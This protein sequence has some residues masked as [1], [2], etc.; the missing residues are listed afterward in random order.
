[1]I[2]EPVP[3]VPREDQD[4]ARVRARAQHGP[5]LPPHPL[6]R[7]KV[8]GTHFRVARWQNCEL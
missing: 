7:R 8:G 4:V 1:M 3:G 6:W 2:S 5:A